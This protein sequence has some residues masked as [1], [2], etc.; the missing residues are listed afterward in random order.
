M[1]IPEQP[2]QPNTTRYEHAVPG[3]WPLR[4]EIVAEDAAA[5][6]LDPATQPSYSVPRYSPFARFRAPE[7]IESNLE[8]EHRAML[9]EL[10]AGFT[11]AQSMVHHN[12][13]R[14]AIHERRAAVR[15]SLQAPSSPAALLRAIVLSEQPVPLV[16]QTLEGFL[17]V[18]HLT[19]FALNAAGYTVAEI[20]AVAPGD[21]GPA[22]LLATTES[23]LLRH[24]PLRP[25]RI[26]AELA[27]VRAFECGVFVV[28]APFNP[29]ETLMAAAP[30]PRSAATS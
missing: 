13:G 22:A 28:G 17:D 9:R 2:V 1:N 16:P 20:D 29:A 27:I 25:H 4:I 12:L 23:V 15:H 26:C 19:C 10:A 30:R 5:A 7:G 14:T 18:R 3:G 11:V 6:A 21:G 24:T 8:P